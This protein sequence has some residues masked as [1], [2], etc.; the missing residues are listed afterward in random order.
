MINNNI[1]NLKT[2]PA[3]T[4]VSVGGAHHAGVIISAT[5]ASITRH[6][7]RQVLYMQLYNFYKKYE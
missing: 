2:S 6:V 1:P 3:Y 7:G 5:L 4:G